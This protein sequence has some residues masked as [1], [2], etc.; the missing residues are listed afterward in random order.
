MVQY[1]DK[2]L[3]HIQDVLQHCRDNEVLEDKENVTQ[4]KLESS[5]LKQGV[6]RRNP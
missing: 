3:E 5:L 2:E 6:F 4:V 1:V